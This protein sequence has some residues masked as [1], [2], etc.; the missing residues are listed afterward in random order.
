MPIDDGLAY[1]IFMSFTATFKQA[2]WLLISF[3]TALWEIILLSLWVSLWAL[4]FALIFSLFFATLIALNEFRGKNLLLVLL[5]AMMGLPPVFIGLLLYIIFSRNGVLGVTHLLYT[6]TIMIIAQAVLIFPIITALA[7]EQLQQHYVYY[8]PLFHNLQL[9][10]FKQSASL[11]YELRFA[12]MI[13]PVAGLGRGLSE[14]GAVLIVGGNIQHFTRTMTTSI[15]LETSRGNISFALALG[16]IL[17]AIGLILNII[18]MLFKQRQK[19][20]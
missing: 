7:I 15:V 10:F 1:N 3:D 19:D 11:L 6:P 9:S 13:L 12:L 8:R 4:L 20:A 14:V 17:V 16:L 2:L 18:F 5:N